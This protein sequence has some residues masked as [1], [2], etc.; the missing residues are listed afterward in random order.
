MRGWVRPST[1]IST[2]LNPA[3]DDKILKLTSVIILSQAEFI[4][5][6]VE[7]RAQMRSAQ[8]SPCYMTPERCIR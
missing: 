6:R 7:G 1:R 5:A 8:I 4:E 3:Q 2:S